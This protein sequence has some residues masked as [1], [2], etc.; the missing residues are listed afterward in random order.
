MKTKQRQLSYKVNHVAQCVAHTW[1]DDDTVGFFYYIN[2]LVDVDLSVS[3]DNLHGLPARR[4][5]GAVPAE[6]HVGERAVHGLRGEEHNNSELCGE[7]TVGACGRTCA[8][9]HH[10]HDV[11]EDGTGGANQS[12]NDRHEIVVEQEA[13]SAECPA[14]VAVQ[15][16]DDHGHVSAADGCRQ[17]YTLTGQKI[18]KVTSP[19]V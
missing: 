3:A 2:G 4:G 15:H 19:E 8:S 16:C 7:R 17:G 11:G 18:E 14:G 1:C 13:F 6:D 5:G 9:T 10:T 12:A